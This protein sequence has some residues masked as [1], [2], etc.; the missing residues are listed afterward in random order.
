MAD[1]VWPGTLP[2]PLLG[3]FNAR[4]NLP[5]IR[6]EMESGPPRA[7]RISD[8]VVS[9]I[10]FNL[11][12]DATQCATFETFFEGDANAG[13]DWFLMPVDTGQGV[14]NHRVR[15]T[16]YGLAIISDQLKRL[17]LSVETEERNA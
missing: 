5:L 8:V 10:N 12:L 15:I 1:P 2:H 9:N 7:S 16:G 11:V 4:R 6:T 14:V 3:G 13:A 17:S